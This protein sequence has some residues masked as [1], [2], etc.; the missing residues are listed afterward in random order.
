MFSLNTIHP[1]IGL[2]LLDG[3]QK[4][5]VTKIS[6]NPSFQAADVQRLDKTSSTLLL[7]QPNSLDVD[8]KVGWD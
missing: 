4:C 8:T 6:W 5:K 2:T 1:L 3:A 7:K